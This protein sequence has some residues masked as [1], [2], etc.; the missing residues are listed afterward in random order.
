M[1]MYSSTGLAGAGSKRSRAASAA[2]SYSYWWTTPRKTTV[3]DQSP[4][5]PS[6]LLIMPRLVHYNYY[7]CSL[8]TVTE[9][10]SIVV[11]N[12]QE[13]FFFRSWASSFTWNDDDQCTLGSVC[14]FFGGR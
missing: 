5:E 4:I 9:V 14:A 8:T 10:V 6:V 7:R 11:L 2:S 3:S 12:C 1:A 13:C